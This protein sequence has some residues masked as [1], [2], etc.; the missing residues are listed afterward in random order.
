MDNSYRELWKMANDDENKINHIGELDLS[1]DDFD[2][3]LEEVQIENQ[4]AEAKLT[5]EPVMK[6]KNK[7]NKKVK[8]TTVEDT[9]DD[10][11]LPEEQTELKNDDF[12]DDFDDFDLDAFSNPDYTKTVGTASNEQND[13]NDDS[14]EDE[15]DDNLNITIDLNIVEDDT[16]NE[17]ENPKTN[18]D[19]TDEAVADE[20]PNTDSQDVDLLSGLEDDFN[21]EN[22][23]DLDISS[24]FEEMTID[25]EDTDTVEDKAENAVI[26][27]DEAIENDSE[28][29]SFVETN[30][31]EETDNFVSDLPLDTSDEICETPKTDEDKTEKSMNEDH[32]EFTEN[33]DN[34]NEDVKEDEKQKLS[35]FEEQIIDLT[36][37]TNTTLS[38]ELCQ[39]IE[40][41][42][43]IQKMIENL[44]IPA[45][46]EQTVFAPSE[47]CMDIEPTSIEELNNK[48]F[49]QLNSFK[50]DLT[51]QLVQLF[52]GIS[53][54][55]ELCEIK[56]SIDEN[57]RQNAAEK[58]DLSDLQ[59]SLDSIQAKLDNLINKDS[60]NIQNEEVDAAE[61]SE[62][63]KTDNETEYSY[64]MEDVESDMAK[65]RLE[66]KE[67]LSSL[68]IV[69][70]KQ[71]EN[72]DSKQSSELFPSAQFDGLCEDVSSI[73]KRT[74][75]LILTSED[76]N[77]TLKHYL[78][79]FNQVIATVNEQA[80]KL[81]AYPQHVS[82]IHTKLDSLTRFTLSSTKSDKIV[83]DA[84]MYI[85]QWIDTT[86][87]TFENIKSD[88]HSI[89]ETGL[90]TLDVRLGTVDTKVNDLTKN[91][92]TKI[93]N[94]EKIST[95]TSKSLEAIDYNQQKRIDAL[96]YKID[97]LSRSDKELK[98]LLET[99]AA[100]VVATN[101]RL[102]ATSA[103]SI[104]EKLEVLE[105]KIAK[106]ERNINKIASY[107]EE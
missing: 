78:E 57:F 46:I 68:D 80:N 107:I 91:A 51:L 105:H 85:A 89:K 25:S 67:I 15:N 58:I 45:P 9:L 82:A 6:P 62:T 21:L 38:K 11:V 34:W 63:Q 29:E 4:K 14:N 8:H 56:D 96:E 10:I 16:K 48:I 50:E 5:E 87:E 60:Q 22:D 44:H 26:K 92:D 77:K 42:D 36:L 86:T 83:N 95:D 24:E 2:L 52:E 39:L 53:F 84:L 30:T 3:D 69:K 12:S 106:F 32:I 81:N 1:I 101:E 33:V 73:S 49:T 13:S 28:S 104:E 66:L 79:D 90:N 55:D 88:L 94:L 31:L 7:K 97:M 99:I 74:N 59:D 98:I 75:K 61:L 40:Q 65:L 70:Q 54:A 100:Q 27:Y 103:S 35:V 93:A 19:T 17:P 23:A 43:T 72:I 71:T 47:N 102:R 76:A 37:N 18:M 64:K 41:I 20:V